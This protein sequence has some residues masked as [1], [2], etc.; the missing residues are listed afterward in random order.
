MKLPIHFWSVMKSFVLPG[1]NKRH[2]SFC[3]FFFVKRP[4]NVLVTSKISRK[5][6]KIVKMV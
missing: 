6:V 4:K 5:T 3:I 1:E 2:I